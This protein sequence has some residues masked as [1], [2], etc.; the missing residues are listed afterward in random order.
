MRKAE[1][2]E[3]ARPSREQQQKSSDPLPAAAERQPLRASTDTW[4]EAATV[5]MSDKGIGA[6]GAVTGRG[7]LFLRLLYLKE[8]QGISYRSLGSRL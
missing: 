5:S 3:L 2:E 1:E 8:A 6:R 4:L 7:C